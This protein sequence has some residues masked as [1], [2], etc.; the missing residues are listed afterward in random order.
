MTIRTEILIN[1]SK[2]KVWDVLTNFEGY[3]IWN[4]FIIESHGKPIEGS[5]LTNTMVSGDG[6]MTFKPKILKMEKYRY[7]DWMGKLIF[8][9]L[10]DGHHYF[11][12]VELGANQVKVVHGENFS[13]LLAGLILKKIGNDTRDNFIKMNLAL[14]AEAESLV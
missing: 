9:G 6:T 10:F 3:S 7:F 11:E 4:P 13:G 5:Y 2:E 12:I 1:A 8:K 14:K